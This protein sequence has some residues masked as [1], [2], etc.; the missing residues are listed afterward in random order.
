MK[1]EIENYPNYIIYN[2]GLVYSMKNQQYLEFCDNGNGY[3][4]INLYNNG[5]QKSSYVHRL[6]AKHFV[7]NPNNYKYVDH[8]DRNK[9]NNHYTNLRWVTASEN[10]KN[11]A[12]Q[13]RYSVSREGIIHRPPYFKKWAVEL[14]TIGYRVFEIADI[15][16]MPRQTVSTYLKAHKSEFPC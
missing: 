11:I 1:T 10:T 7:P 9:D 13:S 5:K 6:V 12:G 16:K 3:K 4:V 8:I 14:Y 2:T 15:L